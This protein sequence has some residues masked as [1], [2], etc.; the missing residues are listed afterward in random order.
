MFST[1]RVIIFILSIGFGLLMSCGGGGIGSASGLAST[2]KGVISDA[3]NLSLFFEQ[4]N[5]SRANHIIGSTQLDA[6]GNFSIEV[7]EGF[8][9]GLYRMRL[10]ANKVIFPVDGDESTISIS[11]DVKSIKDYSFK[12]NGSDT[13]T[14]YVNVLNQWKTG[15]IP[16]LQLEQ[17]L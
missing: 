16:V 13:A 14:K 4:Y 1:N 9:S 17:S 11:G 7:P 15:K 5:M 3:G 2:F 12:M 10:G 8:K 6:D